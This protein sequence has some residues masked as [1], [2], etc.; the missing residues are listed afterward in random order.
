MEPNEP[1]T[2]PQDRPIP[3]LSLGSSSGLR[4]GSLVNSLSSLTPKSV[5]KPAISPPRAYIAVAVLCYINLLNYMERYTI[6]GVL[7]IIQKYFD[8]SDSTAGLLQTGM[9]HILDT[10]MHH[11]FECFKLKKKRKIHILPGLA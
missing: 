4:Y 8:I 11:L 7:P 10:L 9:M 3:R 6:A 2:S 5:E 1:V